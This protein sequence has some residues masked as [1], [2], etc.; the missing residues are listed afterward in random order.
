MSSLV[1][2]GLAS[3]A[4]LAAACGDSAS[5]A[6][7]STVRQS[8]DPAVAGGRIFVEGTNTYG[9]LLDRRM[10]TSGQIDTAVIY[11]AGGQRD[12]ASGR[13]A[14]AVVSGV[15]LDCGL[16]RMR[17]LYHEG[18]ADNGARL[19]RV[20]V[21]RD[22]AWNFGSRVSG[23]ISA[24]CSDPETSPEPRFNGVVDFIEKAGPA[25]TGVPAVAVPTG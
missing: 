16:R 2:T 18:Y 5:S 23:M 15:R 9:E 3:L 22:I 10:R 8:A 20:D 12:P 6:A 13:P 4:L 25:P 19:Y 17:Y 24:L 14:A 21:P 1:R 7:G 11:P